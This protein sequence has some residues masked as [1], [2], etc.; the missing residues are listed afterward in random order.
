MTAVT[1]LLMRCG[2]LAYAMRG[3]TGKGQHYYD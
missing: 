3:G 2:T 1:P